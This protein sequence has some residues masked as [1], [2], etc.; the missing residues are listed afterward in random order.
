[1]LIRRLFLLVLTAL[2]LAAPVAVTP[3]A[4]QTTTAKTAQYTNYAYLASCSG[5][6]SAQFYRGDPSNY[7]PASLPVGRDTA[8][9]FGWDTFWGINLPG[10]RCLRTDYMTS[11]GT[12]HF[13]HVY[14]F[15]GPGPI[16][17]GNFDKSRNHRFMLGAKGKPC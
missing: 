3:A 8:N 6:S 15:N 4:A 17:L 9:S 13:E 5:C 14:Y 7:L 2:A 12:W 11:T 1:M 16:P 10:Y